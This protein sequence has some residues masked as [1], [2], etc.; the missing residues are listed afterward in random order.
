ME[1][2]TMTVT[3]MITEMMVLTTMTQRRKKPELPA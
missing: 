1:P 3:E 2:P